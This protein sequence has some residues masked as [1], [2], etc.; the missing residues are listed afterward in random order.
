MLNRIPEAQWSQLSEV[1]AETMGLHFPSERWADMQRG[2]AE[3]ARELGFEDTAAC[4]WGLLSAPPTKAQIEVLASHLTVGETYFFREK[5]TFDVLANSILPELVRSRRG[6]EQRLRFWSA[7]CCTGEEPYSL[8]MLLHQVIPDLAD[9]HVTIL[10]TDINARFLRKAAAGSYGEWSFRDT[11][12]SLKERYF[13]R[14]AAGR[15]AIRPE[16]RKLV[17]FAHLNLVED[18]YPSLATDTNAMD[19]IFCRNALMYFTPSH[20]RRVIRNLHHALVEGGWLVVS[21][22]EASQALFPQFLAV[23]FPGVILYQKND[24]KLRTG[25]RWAPAP[26]SATAEFVAHA[27]DTPLPWAPQVQVVLP[28]GPVPAPPPEEAAQAETPPTPG[29]MAESLYQQGR[30][31][32][33]V[34][35]LRA[36]IDQ[37]ASEPAAFSLLARALANLG[38]LADA[39]AWCDRWIAADKLDPAAHYLLAVVLLEEGDAEQARASL[40]RALYLRPDF[41]LAHFGLGNLARG[42]GKSDESQRHFA[43]ALHLLGSYQPNDLLPES[44]GLTAGRLTETITAMTDM[45]TTP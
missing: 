16:I 15:Y 36:S 34:D 45:E 20:V 9:W 29:A 1:I 8:A 24:A 19:V 39:R 31:A 14:T 30:Y 17:N 28:M 27:I 42:R 2:M 10:A 5:K 33:A 23:N 25:Q 44:D 21:P 43:N 32:E 7:A 4:V 11:P 37:H 40:Q 13:N 3:A 41:V 18:V 38:N 6:R 35:M 26:L 12:A 22:S